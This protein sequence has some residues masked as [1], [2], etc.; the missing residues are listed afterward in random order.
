MANVVA[1]K[2]GM[3]AN[4]ESANQIGNH[5]PNGMYNRPGGKYPK[6]ESSTTKN[7]WIVSAAPSKV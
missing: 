6:A 7:D 1:R 4:T 2:A 3:I 5:T